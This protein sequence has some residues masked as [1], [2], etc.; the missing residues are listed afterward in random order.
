MDREIVEHHM[1]LQS[2]R[3]PSPHEA[4]VVMAL[5]EHTFGTPAESSSCSKWKVTGI[6]LAPTRD[7]D[8]D[9]DED[10]IHICDRCACTCTAAPA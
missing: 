9:E 10:A 1:P 4:M 7:E 6:C 5:S 2:S 8:E 3:G